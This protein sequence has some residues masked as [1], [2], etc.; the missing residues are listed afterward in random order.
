MKSLIAGLLSALMIDQANAQVYYN[1]PEW[2]RLNDSARA[3]YIAGEIYHH[4]TC[5]NLDACTASG[6]VDRPNWQV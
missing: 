6:R 3:T 5:R 2:D 4:T 1:Y